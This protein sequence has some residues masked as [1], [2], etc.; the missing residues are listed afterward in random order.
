MR[1]AVQRLIACSLLLVATSSFGQT[2]TINVLVL[3][4][5]NGRGIRDVVVWLQFYEAPGSHVLRRI[6][7]KTGPDGVATLPLTDVHP[8]QLTVSASPDSYCEGVVTATTVDILQHG[9][10]SRCNPKTSD[11]PRMP[12]PG[13]VIFLVR[14]FPLW[15]RILAPL[16]RG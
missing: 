13:Q 10:V 6:Q 8:A 2:I 12:N 14:R 7:Y 16:E 5:K 15:Y 3:N 1:R 4:A 9:V 11:S